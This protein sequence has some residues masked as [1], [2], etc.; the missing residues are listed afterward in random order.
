MSSKPQ[1]VFAS[2]GTISFPSLS[3]LQHNV[4]KN[5]FYLKGYQTIQRQ[6]ADDEMSGASTVIWYELN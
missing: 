1:K 2:T 3:I 6:I 4:A 5:T